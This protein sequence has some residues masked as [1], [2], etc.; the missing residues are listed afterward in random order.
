M[1]DREGRLVGQPQSGGVIVAGSRIITGGDVVRM[2]VRAF[3]ADKK[4]EERRCVLVLCTCETG[5]TG[6]RAC[7]AG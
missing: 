3:S 1:K 5:G 6:G 2:S 7:R 4:T